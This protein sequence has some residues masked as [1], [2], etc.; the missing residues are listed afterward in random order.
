MADDVQQQLQDA[1]ARNTAAV[2]SLPSAGMLRHLKSRF[3]ALAGEGFWMECE[4]GQAPLIDELT[5]TE[6]PVGV[7]YKTG[8]LKTVF[9]SPVLD[10]DAEYRLNAETTCFAVKLKLPT[11]I[12][13]MQRRQSYR[14]RVPEDFEMRLE[15]WRIAPRWVLRDKPS[16][17]QR[18][19][20]ELIDISTGGLGVVFI[21]ENGDKPRVCAEDRLRILLTTA[22]TEVLVEGAMKFPLAGKDPS[23][24]RCG[25]QF[26][27]L[28]NDLEGRQ[29]LAK[30]QKIVGELQRH[31]ARRARLGVA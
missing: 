25:L 1:I 14:V 5:R 9:A 28:D 19:E 31:E 27:G 7:S 8:Q 21:G 30:L 2:L 11:E 22:E 20:A 15:I 10:K 18:V 23:R 29:N 6:K 12:K 17:T 3:L 4:P 26:K 13:Q 24:L 16:S